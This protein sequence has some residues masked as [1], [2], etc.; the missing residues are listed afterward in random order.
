MERIDPQCWPRREVSDFFA[1]MEWPFYSLT[2]R[3]DVTA[4]YARAKRGG[5]SVY[6]ATIH[7]VSTAISSVDAFLY[8]LRPDGVV[9]HDRLAPSFTIPG[10]GDLFS[11]LTIDLLPGETEAAFAARARELAKGQSTFLSDPENEARDDLVYCSCL[12]W[13]DFTSLTNERSLDRNDSIPRVGWGKITECGGKRTMPVSVDVN[14]RL[15]DGKHIGQF[16]EALAR[17][18]DGEENA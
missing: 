16:S 18:L 10:Q 15:I 13:L 14:H 7:A 17:A 6:Y 9:K 2:F 12:P 1:G 3:A 8:K 4:L 11:I 5:Y